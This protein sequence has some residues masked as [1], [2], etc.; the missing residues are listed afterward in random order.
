MQQR[1]LLSLIASES[2][3]WDGYAAL[4]RTMAPLTRMLMV[5]FLVTFD[6]RVYEGGFVLTILHDGPRMKSESRALA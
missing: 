2:P 1:I 6:L 4:S 5:L 3:I